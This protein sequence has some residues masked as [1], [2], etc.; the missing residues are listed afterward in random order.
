[1]C[2]INKSGKLLDTEFNLQPKVADCKHKVKTTDMYSENDIVIAMLF[3]AEKHYVETTVSANYIFQ[4][5]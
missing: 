2:P 1:M 5:S 4:S 3:F